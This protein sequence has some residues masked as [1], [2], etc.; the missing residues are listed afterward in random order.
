LDGKII[1][2]DLKFGELVA[3]ADVAVLNG[4]LGMEDDEG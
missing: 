4:N 1:H 3:E 2:V